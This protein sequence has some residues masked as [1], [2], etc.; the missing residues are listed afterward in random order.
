MGELAV[1]SPMCE[2]AID[3]ALKYGN[4]LLKFISANEVDRRQSHQTGFYLPKSAWK[5]YTAHPPKKG[6]NNKHIVNILW[7]D[8]R[9]TESC[10]TWYGNKTRS[11]YRLTRFGKDFPWLT[12][13]TVGSLLILIPAS[14]T[15]FIAYVLDTDDD[16]EEI[17]TGLGVEIVETWGIYQDG[18][19]R[20]ETEDVCLDRHF[21]AFAKAVEVFPQ[22]KVFS[23]TTLNAIIECI[24]GFERASADEQLLRL[25]SEEYRLFRMVE[26]KI[27]QPEV[28][29]LFAS[30]DDFISTALSILNARKSRAGRA[31]ENHVEHLLTKAR[32]P[33]EMRKVVDGTRPDIIIPG[34]AEY[35]DGAYPVEKLLMI[36]V[37]TTCKDRWR[38]VTK[39]APKIK[40]KHIL[41]LQEG[42]SS[43]QLEEMQ[44]SDVTLIVPKPLH[45]KYPKTRRVT[46]LDVGSFIDFVRQL[47]SL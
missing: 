39:E 11:E 35:E 15:E 44:Q 47:H 34:K 31:L 45:K 2:R 23:E 16:I 10:V 25:V 4:A 7:P 9:V 29:R 40:Q 19:P 36:G 8:G 37:K 12:P 24:I 42:I 14:R 27:F 32:I 3:D 38:Q 46:L 26:R 20:M 5:M 22:V 41:T 28:Q 30:I 18:S 43:K 21:R 6:V 13:D 17:L 1:S 33:F